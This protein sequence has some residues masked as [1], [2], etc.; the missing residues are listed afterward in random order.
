MD[1]FP[2]WQ[3]RYYRFLGMLYY[4]AHGLRR[5]RFLGLTL[6]TW[7]MLL[8]LLLFFAVGLWGWGWRGLLG[9]LGLAALAQAAFWV[10]ARA[11]YHKFVPDEQDEAPELA[12]LTP[13]PA[14]RRVTLWATGVFSLIDREDF[15]LLRR[16]TQYWR[17]P[18]GDHILMV[19]QA[20]QRYLY[21]IFNH[22]TLRRVQ[23]GWFIFGPQPHRAL[24]I[25]FQVIF[26]PGLDDPTLSYYVGGGLN[27]RKPSL[28]TIYLSFADEADYQAVWH[29]ILRDFPGDDVG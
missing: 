22:G 7:L 26:G 20:P 14:E 12:A 23:P 27:K 29:T 17:V 16:P 25:T 13:L 24:A 4:S 15:V 10:S 1:R 3:R 28:R 11:G 21:Q 8:F 6:H 5:R 9:V 2:L 19:E 18:L